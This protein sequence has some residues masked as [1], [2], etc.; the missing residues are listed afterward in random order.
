[1]NAQSKRINDAGN[2]V[3]DVVRNGRFLATVEIRSDASGGMKVL[4]GALQPI[5][6]QKAWD[7]IRAY[8]LPARS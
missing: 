2:A 4:L 6:K 7:A 3:F 5:G 8:E 1:M